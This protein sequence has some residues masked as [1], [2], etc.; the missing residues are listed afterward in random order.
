MRFSEDDKMKI[1]IS[2]SFSKDLPKRLSEFGVVTENKKDVPYADVILVRSATKVDKAYIDAAKKMKFVI[3]GGV[4][5]DNIDVDYCGKK[6]IL[7]KNTPEASTTAVAELVFA[8]MLGITRNV[9]KAHNTTKNGQ[10]V[11]DLK[12]SELYGKTLGIVGL[13]RIG[14]EVAKRAKAFGM[15]VIACEKHSRPSEYAQIVSMD[16]VL[17]KSDFISLHVPLT[18]ETEEMINKST[19]KKMNDGVIIINTARGKLINESDLAEALKTGKV[20]YAGLDVY[21]QEPPAGSPLLLLEN[22][23]LMPHLG[24]QTYENMQRIGDMV[25]EMI[26]DFRHAN[27]KL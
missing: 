27:P 8:L 14:T 11:K 16:D 17:R 23:L 4:G 9:V 13:G 1:L 19:L 3:R 24:A 10:W 18:D 21:Q 5:L 22:V 25:C 2:D 20:R 15:N 26:R 12:G 7:V 6:G